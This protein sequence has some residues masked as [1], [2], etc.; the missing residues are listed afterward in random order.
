V[1]AA[2][3][4]D[5]KKTEQHIKLAEVA[6]PCHLSPL[7]CSFI[8]QVGT[9]WVGGWVGGQGVRLAYADAACWPRAVVADKDSGAS[10]AL[11]STAFTLCRR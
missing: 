2:Q 1:H 7:C 3:V 10:F 5:V 6:F 8:Q 9:P 4:E 11:H